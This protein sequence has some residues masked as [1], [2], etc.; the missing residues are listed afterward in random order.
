VVGDF[1]QQ[2][3]LLYLI[4]K[5][6]KIFS[7]SANSTKFALFLGKQKSQYFY[8]KKIEPRKTLIVT[9]SILN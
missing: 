7:F 8:M 2:F 5:F 3:F 6:E 4:Q 9:T 1:F